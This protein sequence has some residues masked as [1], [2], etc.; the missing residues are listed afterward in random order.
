MAKA[1]PITAKRGTTFIVN[2][3]D[4]TIDESAN[5]RAFPYTPAEIF[6]KAASLK[7]LG[8]LQPIVVQRVDGKVLVLA[9]TGRALGALYLN[10]NDPDYSEKPFLL[11]CTVQDDEVDAFTVNV[12][13]NFQRKS[14]S[15]VDIAH[16]ITRSDERQPEGADE[17]AKTAAALELFGLKDTGDNRKWIARHRAIGT[18]SMPI[19]RKIHSKSLAV[20]AALEYVGMDPETAEAVHASAEADAGGKKVTK[21][22][23]QKAAAKAGAPAKKERA[24]SNAISKPALVSFLS[25]QVENNKKT[26]VKGLCNA[27]LGYLSGEVVEPEMLKALNKFTVAN[28]EK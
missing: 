7:A 8:Q 12:A 18:L 10:Q 20:D 17:D 28:A 3:S 4:L 21:A 23:V 15:P 27:F 24:V 16:N 25:Y 2:P 6:T 19:K 1:F 14:L 22:R 26:A 5:G 9:G 13:E 11:E